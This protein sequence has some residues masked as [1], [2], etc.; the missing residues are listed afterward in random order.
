MVS[1]KSKARLYELDLLRFIA[2]ISVLLYHYTFMGYA[3][4]SIQGDYTS[5]IEYPMLAPFSQ[6]TYLGVN[7]FFM[8]SGFVILLS[9]HGMT[10]VFLWLKEKIGNPVYGLGLGFVFLLAFF[11]N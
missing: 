11:Q 2:A 7:L 4:N 3:E 6:Y 8:I 10:E 1:Q 9:A 5:P